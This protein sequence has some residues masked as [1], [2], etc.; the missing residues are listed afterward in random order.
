MLLMDMLGVATGA[1]LGEARRSPRPTRSTRRCA[2]GIAGAFAIALVA[3]VALAAIARRIPSGRRDRAR[4]R[5]SAR[6]RRACSCPRSSARSA[7]PST[8]RWLV[9]PSASGFDSVWVGDHLLYRDDGRPA[10]GP[11]EAWT[12]LAAIAASTDR[13]EL[14]PL[15]ACVAFHAPAMLAK[16]AATV[17]EISGGRLVLALGAGWNETEFR[18]FGLPVRAASVSV[19]RSRSR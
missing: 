10:R 6:A 18:A 7:G 17:D 3:A 19:S 2:P 5:L 15:V 12:T 8:S 16:Q 1:G 14:G 4:R 13:V 11:W 9:Q